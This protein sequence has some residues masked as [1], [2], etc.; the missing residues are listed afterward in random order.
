M[1]ESTEQGSEHLTGQGDPWVRWSAAARR[2]RVSPDTLDNWFALGFVPKVTSPGVAFTYQSWID[3]I[4]SAMP[5]PAKAAE[6]AEVGRAWFAAR[7][8]DGE[9][10]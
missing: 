1:P 4:L 3:D 8:L 6:I 2:I 7:G 5:R 9:A 10:A